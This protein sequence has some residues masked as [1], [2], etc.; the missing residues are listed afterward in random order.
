MKIRQVYTN[1]FPK[2]TYFYSFKIT[3]SNCYKPINKFKHSINDFLE[4]TLGSEN[5]NKAD[6]I[7]QNVYEM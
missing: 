3:Q 4:G 2:G 6:A 1:L 7:L 5:D